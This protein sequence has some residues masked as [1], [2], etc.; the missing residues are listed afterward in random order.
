MRKI[1]YK[2]IIDGVIELVINTSRNIP[3]EVKRY[4]KKAYLSESGYGKKYLEIILKNFAIAEKEKLPICQ[5][6][7]LAVFFVELGPD[8]VIDTGR[9]KTLEDIINEGL[10]TGSK[11]GY[12]RNSV[13]SAIDRKNTGTNSPGIIHIIPASKGIFRIH[14]LSKGF[15]SENT[16][17]I[18]MLSPTGGKEMIENFIVET[19][20]QAG[21]LPCPPLF[22]GVG[23]G[24]SFEKAAVLS[25]LALCNIGKESKHRRWEKKILSM[26]NMLNI[27]PA[28]LGGKNTA[29]DVR[30]EETPTHI[31]GLPVAVNISCWAHRYGWIEL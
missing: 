19:V 31:A 8:I 1:S 9:Y 6:T 30:V 22:V 3:D 10:Q 24:G 13:V 20:K 11:K 17:K 26:I 23:I 29:L 4:I 21:S 18:A 7:G 25:K 5:D 16:S 15:G 28:G 2:K 27:G 12:L 14:L